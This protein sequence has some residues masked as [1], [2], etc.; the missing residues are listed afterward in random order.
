M[1]GCLWIIIPDLA[2]NITKFY[3]NIKK[4]PM[5]ILQ[6]SAD[7]KVT[8]QEASQS[9]KFIDTI[10]LKCCK[11][12]TIVLKTTSIKRPIKLKLIRKDKSNN[13]KAKLLQNSI[14]WKNTSTKLR[15]KEKNSINLNL[16]RMLNF[17]ESKKSKISKI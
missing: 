3:L 14:S 10:E 4:V 12:S 17:M 9:I 1:K 6:I 5:D 8:F 13:F 11:K 15:V 2:L 16:N 7:K